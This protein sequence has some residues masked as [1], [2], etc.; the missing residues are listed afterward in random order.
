MQDS[1]IIS[2]HED[3]IT[4]SSGHRDETPWTITAAQFIYSIVHNTMGATQLIPSVNCYIALTFELLETSFRVQ[5]SLHSDLIAIFPSEY[6]FS[7]TA[8][9]SVANLLPGCIHLNSA[10]IH[11]TF[12]EK[13]ITLPTNRSEIGIKREVNLRT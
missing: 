1:A 6:K 13:I 8:L 10:R 2:T 4:G 7:G 9:Y 3:K 5:R 11:G 12:C